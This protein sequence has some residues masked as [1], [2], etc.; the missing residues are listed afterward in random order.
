MNMRTALTPGGG[1]FAH[2]RSRV[3]KPRAEDTPADPAEDPAETEEEK[4]ARKARAAEGD[5][6]EEDDKPKPNEA[7]DA[8]EG[9]D[10]EGEK[11]P[12]E[13]MLGNTP[14]AQARAR[15]R[16][17][18]MA[19]F[20]DAAADANPGL[21]ATLAFETMLPRDQAI[22]VLRAGGV[23]QGSKKPGLSERMAAVNA[24][25][26][27]PDAPAVGPKEAVAS[28]WD[29]IRQSSAARRRTG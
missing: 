20:A 15:E 25:H 7:E 17:R 8:P 16:A 19:I 1:I 29:G 5:A 4:K 3:S 28:F 2:L 24:P 6:P 12:D 18:C 21:A 14:A 10:D 27:T 26:I 11:N 13:E 9:E 22:R 23:P